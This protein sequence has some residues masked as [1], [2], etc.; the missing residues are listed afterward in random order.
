MPLRVLITEGSAADCSDA[1]ELLRGMNAEYLLADKGYNTD[2]I[3]AKGQ[4]QGMEVLIPP[5]RNRNIQ[6]PYDKDLYRLW[7]LERK[8]IPSPEAMARHCYSLRKKCLFLP[9][10]HSD[11]LYCHLG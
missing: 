8:H 9:R 3:I 1:P 6:R 11:P 2:A 4:R 10:R 7:H 5:K